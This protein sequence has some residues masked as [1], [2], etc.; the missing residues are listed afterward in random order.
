MI[1]WDLLKDFRC[2]KCE[3]DLQEGKLYYRRGCNFSISKGKL[4]DMVGKK[5]SLTKTK[6][7]ILNK[8]KK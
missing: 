2:P 8:L 1:N 5:T 7:K 3:L 4:I 6:D